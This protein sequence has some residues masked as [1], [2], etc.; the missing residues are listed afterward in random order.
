MVPLR[1]IAWVSP[2]AL[3]VMDRPATRAATAAAGWDST[4]S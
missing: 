4:T 2:P 3:R 1:F